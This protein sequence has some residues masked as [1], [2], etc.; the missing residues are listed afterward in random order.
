MLLIN[1]TKSDQPFSRPLLFLVESKAVDSAFCSRFILALAFLGERPPILSFPRG[2]NCRS[3]LGI[4]EIDV[5]LLLFPYPPL[6]LF[7]L[8]FESMRFESFQFRLC[9][10]FSLNKSYYASTVALVDRMFLEFRLNPVWSQSS[11]LIFEFCHG[12][13]IGIKA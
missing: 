3:A 9:E 2:C 12:I 4:V 10:R 8:I 6:S 1:R 11:L 13:R 7:F 5:S